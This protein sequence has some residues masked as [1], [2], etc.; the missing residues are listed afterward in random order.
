MFTKSKIESI[1]TNTIYGIVLGAIIV[2]WLLPMVSLTGVSP[3]VGGIIGGALGLVYGM[4]KD[5]EGNGS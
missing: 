1:V 3:W 5:D 2:L 4:A